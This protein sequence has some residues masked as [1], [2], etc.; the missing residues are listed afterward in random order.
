MGDGSYVFA[1]G[2]AAVKGLT[3]T[4]TV[5]APDVAEPVSFQ[6]NFDEGNVEKTVKVLVSGVDAIF[7]G[8]QGAKNL[9]GKIYVNGDAQIFT[10]DGK[11][12]RVVHTQS[13]Q[14]VEGLQPGLYI[15]A[16]QK[17]IVK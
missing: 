14:E 1:A 12:V 10:I 6:F 13:A 4:A 3:L 8:E 15:V 2:A 7:A 11:L 5:T 9:A 16:G 17:M